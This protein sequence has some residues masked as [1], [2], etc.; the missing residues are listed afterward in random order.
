MNILQLSVD[1]TRYEYGVSMTTSRLFLSRIQDG[2]V[3]FSA[4]CTCAF[5][6]KLEVLGSGKIHSAVGLF[7]V[8]LY[9]Y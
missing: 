4:V 2:Q 7:E 8:Q 5:S 6:L 1:M 3:W 9:S